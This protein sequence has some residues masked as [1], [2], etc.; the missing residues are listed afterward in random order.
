MSAVENGVAVESTADEAELQLDLYRRMLTIRGVEDLVQALFLRATSTGRRTCTRGRRLWPSASP[1]RW[2]QMTAL[3]APYR[4]HGHALARGLEPE[5]L[6]AELLGRETGV[7]GGR[8][9]SM[10]V[11][12]LDHGLIRLL[13]ASVGGSMAAAPASRYA[14]ARQ[15]ARRVRLLR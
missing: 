1:A 3:P 9:G 2:S 5:A 15:A 12:D 11:V 10:N 13:P 8:A 4:G 6:I 14:N 7:N